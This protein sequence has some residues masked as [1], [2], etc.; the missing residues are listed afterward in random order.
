METRVT[1]VDHLRSISPD[2]GSGYPCTSDSP[3]TPG[4]RQISAE[5]SLDLRDPNVHVKV[6][7][8]RLM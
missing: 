8:N 1:V 2:T 4:G 6:E 5:T 3:G 7:E